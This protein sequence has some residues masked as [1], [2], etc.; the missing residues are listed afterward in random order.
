MRY[1]PN[2]VTFYH[3]LNGERVEVRANVWPGHPGSWN[4]HDGGTPP[5]AG[6]VE[7]VNVKRVGSVDMLDLDKLPEDV[8]DEMRRAAEDALEAERLAEEDD[9]ADAKY[10][11]M[12]E[13]NRRHEA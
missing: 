13:R 7:I 12:R 5:D 8:M 6:E 1:R 2:I 9:A 10:E 3:V 11:D 4:P